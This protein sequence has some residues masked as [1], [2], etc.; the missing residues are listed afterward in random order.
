MARADGRRRRI[1][2]SHVSESNQC[3]VR[4]IKFRLKFLSQQLLCNEERM[5]ACVHKIMPMISCLSLRRGF[6]WS[7]ITRLRRWCDT[8][9][10]MREACW[11]NQ[12]MSWSSNLISI[13]LYPEPQPV[14]GQCDPKEDSDWL[15]III[16]LFSYHNIPI[17][18]GKLENLSPSNS[19][20]P[21]Y[22]LPGDM[23]LAPRHW[24]NEQKISDKNIW[25]A[26]LIYCPCNNLMRICPLPWYTPVLSTDPN[27]TNKKLDRKSPSQWEATIR[28][29]EYLQFRRVLSAQSNKI[30]SHKLGWTQRY[31]FQPDT[32]THNV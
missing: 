7:L 21:L 11:W 3:W 26:D 16:L 28:S 5:R 32:K 22:S 31:K 15:I 23:R 14:I 6:D 12:S 1:A 4:N 29:H 9:I 13:I 2:S 20:L 24:E 25:C 10:G 30:T 18:D 19:L 17:A 8:E 27:L